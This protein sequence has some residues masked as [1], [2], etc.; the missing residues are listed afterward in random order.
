MRNENLLAEFQTKRYSATS[1]GESHK[2]QVA[3][4]RNTHSRGWTVPVHHRR[5]VETCKSSHEPYI[6]VCKFLL[7]QMV[8]IKIL[9]MNEAITYCLSQHYS[10][11]S[12]NRLVKY[13]FLSY[14]IRYYTLLTVMFYFLCITS[15]KNYLFLTSNTSFINSFCL[16]ICW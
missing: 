3:F 14:T 1:S 2:L 4:C 11:F 13:W 10:K 5:L 16:T 8:C 7:R 6:Y 9:F 12:V 15:F